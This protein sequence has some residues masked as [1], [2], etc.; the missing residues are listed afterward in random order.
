M[1]DRG[2]VQSTSMLLGSSPEPDPRRP[3]RC[4]PCCKS[5]RILVSGSELPAR[6][7]LRSHRPG[8]VSPTPRPT[9]PTAPLTAI[10]THQAYDAV[11]DFKESLLQ[12]EILRP[13]DQSGSLSQLHCCIHRGRDRL[14]GPFQIRDGHPDFVEMITAQRCC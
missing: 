8:N 2:S 1:T 12:H 10:F 13:A 14:Q 3:V 6:R 9:H 5:C 7:M 4:E 11:A